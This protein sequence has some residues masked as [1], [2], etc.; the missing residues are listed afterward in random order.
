MKKN[1]LY[2]LIFMGTIFLMIFSDFKSIFIYMREISIERFIS[3]LLLQIITIIIITIQWKSMVLLIGEKAKTINI[4]RMNMK[5]N[6]VDAITPGVKVGGEMARVHE[7]ISSLDLNLSEAIIVVGLQKTIS[8][9]SFLSLTIVSIIWFYLSMDQTYKSLLNIFILSILILGIALI[10]VIFLCM[11]PGIIKRLLSKISLKQDKK[12]KL[13]EVFLNYNKSLNQ[14]LNNKYKFVG[15]MGL[16]IFIWILFAVKMNLI[17]KG[18]NIKMDYMSISAIT[19]LTYMVGMIPLLPGSIG[20]FETSMVTL[21]A[22]K[23]LSIEKAIAISVIFRF[24][25]FWFEFLISLVGLLIDK[26]I[27]RTTKDDKYARN[28]Y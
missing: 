22:I 24:V 2:F 11:K 26:I 17:V 1:I 12:E 8:L 4:I 15:Q 5:G 20:S 16:G 25:T 3:L 21:L 23:G 28:Q 9:L 14:L 27:F 10:T 18:F 13:E 6:I 7:I 19:Y